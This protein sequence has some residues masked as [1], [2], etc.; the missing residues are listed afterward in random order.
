MFKK[1]IIPLV[2]LTLLWLVTSI[3]ESQEPATH[4]EDVPLLGPED[5]SNTNDDNLN[6]A[7]TL[8]LTF[9]P[10]SGTGIEGAAT[11]T[12]PKG[13]KVMAV[14]WAW[15]NDKDGDPLKYTFYSSD[16]NVIGPHGDNWVMLPADATIGSY[17]I[18]V[19]VEDGRGGSATETAKFYVF[20]GN[21]QQGDQE[22][23]PQG[24]AES[25]KSDIQVPI[26][27]TGGRAS[28]DSI[29]TKDGINYAF[30]GVMCAKSPEVPA[31]FS[32]S[33]LPQEISLDLQKL[34]LNRVNA[35][36]LG[37]ENAYSPDFPSGV[38]VASVICEYREGGPDTKIDLVIGE[39]TAEW[40]YD[41]PEL[42]AIGQPLHTK[43]PV[44][45]SWKTRVDSSQ[46]YE[47][48]TY[49]AHSPLD[50]TRTLSKIRL[51]LVDADQLIKYRS[52]NNRNP[53]WLAQDI[54]AIT[55]VGAPIEPNARVEW[56]GHKYE[57]IFVPNGITW[58]EAKSAAENT[59]G[60]LVGIDSPAENKF[61][62]S[63]I[64]DDKFWT[65]DGLNVEGPLVGGYRKPESKEP[66][67][68]WVWVN[69]DKPFSYTN[70]GDG[71]PNNYKG[72]ED[73]TAFFGKGTTK[74]EKWND[75]KRSF[76]SKG[77]IVE[78]D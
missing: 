51:E 66:A 70:W 9:S 29:T 50:P 26:D 60:Y 76:K 11:E 8:T 78:W 37:T 39:N 71:E 44:I 15:G 30:I 58:D 22:G 42:R 69:G 38:K 13:R 12:D 25:S 54:S 35:I 52:S 68:G 23:Y 28:I 59:S 56:Q 18:R 3:A 33:S 48:H 47:G 40:A 46:E 31:S 53:S 7:P 21:E 43:A 20:S 61:V 73:V 1:I 6:H 36:Y 49:D 64:Q 10:S 24:P 62:F 5:S 41:R 16:G 72:I 34:G 74:G 77:Y 4:S 17:P 55:L 57:A 45:Y 2:F 63:L 32:G 27:S 14:L 19:T 67:S 65:W 75:V